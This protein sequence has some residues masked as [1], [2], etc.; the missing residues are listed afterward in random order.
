VLRNNFAMRCGL[1]LKQSAFYFQAKS[2]QTLLQGNI[3]FHG[4]RS[5]IN[6]NDG[7][8]GGSVIEINHMFATV[9][10]TNSWDRQPYAHRFDQAQSK[11]VFREHLDE[12]RHNAFMG[13]YS[14]HGQGTTGIRGRSAHEPAQHRPRPSRRVAGQS[15]AE[16]HRR[17]Y[18]Q[19]LL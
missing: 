12:I 15:Q 16:P 9:M 4:P 7:V 8:G 3:S 10:E 11:F 13:N 17:V 18:M 2:M 19:H 14:A 5:G 6:F 1:V